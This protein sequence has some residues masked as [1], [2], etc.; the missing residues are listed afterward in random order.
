MT[1]DTS[2]DKIVDGLQSI[3]KACGR[4]TTCD[5]CLMF[6]VDGLDC[7]LCIPELG[8]FPYRWDLDKLR[9]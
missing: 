3:K 4:R 9:G 6:D 5:D 8:G 7:R 1:D 2:I